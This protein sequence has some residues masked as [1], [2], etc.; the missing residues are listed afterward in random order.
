MQD[1]LKNVKTYSTLHSLMKE[2]AAPSTKSSV[3]LY[4]ETRKLLKETFS[5]K[6]QFQ[7]SIH[8]CTSVLKE[9]TTSN[10]QMHYYIFLVVSKRYCDMMPESQNSGVRVVLRRHPLLGTGSVNTLPQQ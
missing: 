3:T 7:L 2:Y 6:L 5:L 9:V 1:V 10:S 4:S 8:I